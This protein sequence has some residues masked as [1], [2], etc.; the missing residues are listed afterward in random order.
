MKVVIQ[1][2]RKIPSFSQ[3]R[4]KFHKITWA[5][6]NGNLIL[7]SF[8][9][10]VRLFWYDFPDCVCVDLF[11]FLRVSLTKYTF[12]IRNV[13]KAFALYM[14]FHVHSLHHLFEM[15]CHISSTQMASLVCVLCQVF[16]NCSLLVND[17]SH[18]EQVNMA[19]I[20]CG[21]CHAPSNVHFV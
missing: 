17:L 8:E 5:I 16:F 10:F 12:H 18:L 7:V 9:H 1:C 6:K 20:L 2:S 11:I 13:Q 19:S 15:S 3:T 4:D 14:S 21:F